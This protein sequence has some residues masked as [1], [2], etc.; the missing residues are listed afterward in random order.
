MYLVTALEKLRIISTIISDTD[1]V[2]L[3][4]YTALRMAK[5]VS[6]V[7]PVCVFVCDHKEKVMPEKA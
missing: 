5:G 3:P 1:M 7:R 4:F 6:T 2:T